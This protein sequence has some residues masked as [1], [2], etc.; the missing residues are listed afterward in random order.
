MALHVLAGVSVK[1]T[2]TLSC[3]VV[4]F[5]KKLGGFGSID[6][7]DPAHP[8]W[9][10]TYGNLITRNEAP[11]P[12]LARAL[13]QEGEGRSYGG[14]ILLRQQLLKG[15]FGWITYS[16]SRSE[17]KD[18]LDR[19]WRLFDFDQTHVLGVVASY[20]YRGWVAGVRFRYT[21]GV[22]RTPVTGAF[23]DG[24][25]DQY[26]PVF[27]KQNSIRIPDFVQLDLR[28][29][30][31]FTFRRG[32]QLNVYVD[33][34]NVTNRANPEEIVYSYDFTKRAFITGLPTL[35]VLGARVQW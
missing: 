18:H 3:E 12:P 4:G 10:S 13:V 7:H 34:Q 9:S 8:A 24:R 14:Q 19:D 21:T 1:I 16:L 23:Y 31:T 30:K 29:E 26:Q 11:T 17:R 2:G 22:P 28:L 33:V 32:V 25:G 6:S 27:G 15:F 5:Y 20:E 35:A